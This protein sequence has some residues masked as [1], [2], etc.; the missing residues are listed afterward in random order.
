MTADALFETLQRDGVVVLPRLLS[1]DA[2]AKMKFAFDSRLRNLRWNDVDGYEKTERF[3]HMIHDVLQLEQGFVDLALH[4]LV[5]EIIGRYV[6]PQYQ[7]T[8]AKGW[9]SLRTLANFHGWHMDS[10]YAQNGVTEI[11]REVKLATYL[12]DVKSGAFNYIRGTQRKTHTRNVTAEEVAAFPKEQTLELL[13]AA[14]TS[15]LFDSSGIH[16]QACPVLEPRCAVFYN[17][18]DAGVP[19]QQ[20]DIDYYR[21]HPLILN[22]AFLGGLSAEQMRVLGF[23]DKRRFVPGFARAPAHTGLQTLNRSM[24]DTKVAVQPL[25]ERVGGRLRR[26]MGGGT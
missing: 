1:D 4:P 3:R 15:F 22:A 13:G 21:Y 12:T 6:G 10:W 18:H 25:V 16:R 14:G 7:L 11:P 9:K 24:L 8:E 5:L 23:G 26:L 17:Y 19:V 20:E 2:L